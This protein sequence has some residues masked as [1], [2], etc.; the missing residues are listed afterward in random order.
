M[1]ISL[2]A[3]VEMKIAENV[4]KLRKHK[5]ERV[6]LAAKKLRRQWKSLLIE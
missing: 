4:S 1:D 3:L 5:N 6:M 2:V